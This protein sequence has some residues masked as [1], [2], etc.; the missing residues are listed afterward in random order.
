MTSLLVNL[1]SLLYHQELPTTLTFTVA[2]S[3][4]VLD[5]SAFYRMAQSWMMM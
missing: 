3:K 4:Y 2:K 5:L 1:C